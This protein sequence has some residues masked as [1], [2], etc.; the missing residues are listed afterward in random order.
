M[1]HPCRIA[2]APIT[3]Q[4][5]IGSS[6]Q[7][8]IRRPLCAHPAGRPGILDQP[9]REITMGSPAAPIGCLHARL[10]IVLVARP[11]ASRFGA[12]RATLLRRYTG[13]A[14]SGARPRPAAS[15][16]LAGASMSIASGNRCAS[17]LSG[18]AARRD[19]RMS[20]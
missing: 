17:T 9:Q 3:S 11:H 20:R 8:G 5:V 2:I 16:S 6:R 10:R 15:S 4:R 18:L 13:A 7:A 1:V 12:A 14:S 19:P